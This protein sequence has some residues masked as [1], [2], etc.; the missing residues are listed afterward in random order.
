MSKIQ[1]L[2]IGRPECGLVFMLN[3]YVHVLSLMLA[4]M[5]Q[6][7]ADSSSSAPGIVNF[8]CERQGALSRNNMVLDLGDESA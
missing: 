6:E 8:R 5:R 3:S 7:C 4:E 1:A 2:M